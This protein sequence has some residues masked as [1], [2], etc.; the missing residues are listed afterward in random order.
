MES[1]RVLG[2]IPGK[3]EGEER[4]RGEIERGERREER[5]RKERTDEKEGSDSGFTAPF[6]QTFYRLRERG[7]EERNEVAQSQRSTALQSLQSP[8]CP[9]SCQRSL[10]P[11]PSVT[12][13]GSE[14]VAA[15]PGPACPARA[16]RLF[17]G[18]LGDCRL[19]LPGAA[20]R[21]PARCGGAWPSVAGL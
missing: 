6:L 19:A 8:V 18:A 4:D 10:D 5:E 14:S 15:I 9:P 3:R 1:P 21:S 11:V 12:C 20:A 17:S 7:E 16:A 13:K 2:W